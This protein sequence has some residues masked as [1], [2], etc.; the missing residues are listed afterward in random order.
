MRTRVALLLL[1]LAM[2]PLT[3]AASLPNGSFQDGDDRPAGWSLTG[4]GD[5][6]AGGDERVISVS[7]TGS[8]TSLWQTEALA[9][10]PGGLYRLSFRMDGSNATGGCAIAGPAFCNRDFTVGRPWQECS[11]VFAAPG[12][13]GL[14]NA[15]VRLGQWHT[16][17]T[18]RFDDAALTGCVPIHRRSGGLELGEGEQVDGRTYVFQAPLGGEATNYSRPLHSFTA[19]FNTNRWVFAPGSEVIYAHELPGRAQTAATVD[20]NCNYHTGGGGLVEASTDGERWRQIGRFDGVARRAFDLPATMLPASR[21]L[22]RI[23]SP[24]SAGGGMDPGAFQVDEYRYAA[25]LDAAL[26]PISG[27]T[28]YSDVAAAGPALAVSIVPSDAG[29]LRLGIRNLSD[30]E[31]TFELRQTVRPEVQ[32]EGSA[33]R[34]VRI[35]AGERELFDAPDVPHPPGLNE[36][37]LSVAESGRTLYS[38]RMQD[39]VTPLDDASYGYALSGDGTADVWWCEGTHKVSRDRPAPR[40]AGT[41]I[42]LSAAGNE[43]EPVQLVLRPARDLENVRVRVSELKGPGASLTADNISVREVAYVKVTRPTD[44]AGSAG[45]WPDPLPPFEQGCR[46]EAGVNHPVWLT[47]YVPPDQ[48][49]GLYRGTVEVSADG[50]RHTFDLVLRVWGFSLPKEPSLQTAF[51]LDPQSI[52]RYHN[53]ETTDELREVLDLYFRD[54]AAHR[55]APYDPAPLDPIRVSFTAGGWDGGEYDA[56]TAHSG[57][58]S[59]KVVDDDESQSVS[60][61]TATPIPVDGSRDYALRWW[62]RTERPGQP[63]LVSIQQYDADRQW[64]PGNNL[65]MARTG[66]GDWRREES[67]L[68]AERLSPQT[69]FVNVVLRPAPW[70]ETGDATGTAWFDDISFRAA[71]GEELLTDGGLELRPE[72]MEARLD[73]AGFDRQCERYLDGLGFNSVMIRLQGMPG[74]TFHARSAGRI[75]PFSQGTPEYEQLMASQGRQIAEHLREKGWLGKAYV[76]WFDE[77]DPKDYAFVVDGMKLLARAAPGLARMLTEQPEEALAP[78]VDLWCPVV[79][80]VGP[81]AIGERE[82]QGDRFWWYLCTTPKAPYMGLFI[83]RPAADLRVWPWLSRKW[84][85]EGLLVWSANYWNSTAAFPPPDIQDPWEDPMG[86]VSGYSFEPGRIGYW[87]NGDGR[88]LYPPNRSVATDGSKYLGGPVDSVRWEMLREGIE[89][90][91]YFAVLDALVKQGRQAQAP[92]ELIARGE[93]L[94]RVPEAVIIDDRTYSKDPGPLYEHRRLVAEAIEML[95]AALH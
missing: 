27:R 28:L 76:Y 29:M 51:G 46:L 80:A 53:L 7:G 12:A 23:R 11:F 88:F 64:L 67:P 33:V 42:S 19:G 60:A 93:R 70:T 85:V 5:W 36:I 83:D 86:Y 1:A 31:R 79:S 63:Y 24:L 13:P 48:A 3:R 43:Y 25:E 8:D 77:P 74:G 17:G 90:Y 49:P 82:A 37:V 4:A 65:D 72:A 84:G 26:P 95:S 18:I 91:E 56:T 14:A 61:S 73:F 44:G 45:Y 54:F 16:T 32:S 94:S 22:V 6:V 52:R 10:E 87:G 59:L 35:A 38:A 92:A 75:G 34:T 47:V 41:P 9:L 55:I 57:R 21:V 71:G 68:S 39:R 15:F 20:V 81:Q 66:S 62:A 30:H 78:Y 2:A 40:S 89:D 58:R 69:R 50:W